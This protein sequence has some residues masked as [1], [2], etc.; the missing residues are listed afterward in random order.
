MR[1]SQ[2]VEW[3]VH[4]CVTLGWLGASLPISTARLAKHFDLP[5]AYLNKALQALVRSGVLVSQ[6]GPHGGFRLARPP[7]SISLWDVVSAIDGI[8]HSFRCTE[9]RQNGGAKPDEC[10]RPCGIAQAMYDAEDAWRESLKNKTIADMMAAAPAAA[11]ER[12]IRS[13][14]VSISHS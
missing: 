9:I 5:P 8:D 1:I 3:A 11:A 13:F 2:S 10:T 4:C 6:A 7:S 12:T 14:A